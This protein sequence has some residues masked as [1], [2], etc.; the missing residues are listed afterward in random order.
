M[1]EYEPDEQSVDSSLFVMEHAPEASTTQVARSAQAIV[2]SPV[3][4]NEQVAPAA[5]AQ[6]DGHVCT[7]GT[8]S[9][10]LDAVDVVDPLPLELVDVDDAAPPSASGGTIV[11]SCEQAPAPTMHNS[12]M[13]FV[14]RIRKA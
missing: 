10:E 4:R 12:V 14:R 8:G 1:Q 11:H 13:T 2:H 7:T 9:P 5:H 3:Q 6:S